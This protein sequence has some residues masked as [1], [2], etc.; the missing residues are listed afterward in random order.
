[1]PSRQ[2]ASGG[3]K[4]YFFIFLRDTARA[5]RPTLLV[6]NGVSILLFIES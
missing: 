4:D 3:H 2:S 5:S 6:P 1:M